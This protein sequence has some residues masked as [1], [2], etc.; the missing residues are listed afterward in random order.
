[1]HSSIRRLGIAV[2]YCYYSLS[3]RE[4]KK[5]DESLKNH[6]PGEMELLARELMLNLATT[7]T[8]GQ[9]AQPARN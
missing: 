5:D 8:A 7:K 6:R 1:M 3:L 2:V 9:P 4:F